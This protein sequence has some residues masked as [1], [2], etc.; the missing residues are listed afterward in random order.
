MALVYRWYSRDAP[1]IRTKMSKSV[2]HRFVTKEPEGLTLNPYIG[3]QHRCV[4]CYATYE[5]SP[6]FY[7]TVYAKLNSPEVLEREVKKWREKEI[8]PVMFSSATDCYQQIESILG[9]TRSC[10]EELQKQGVPYLIITKSSSIMRD[11]ELHARYRDKCA[12]VWSLTTLD[13]KTKHLIEPYTSTAKNILR[14][15]NRF[16]SKGVICGVNIDPIIP[17]ITDSYAMLKELVDQCADNGARFISAGML[18]LRSDIW[19]RMKSFM[20][21]INRNDIV[22]KFEKIYFDNMVK[23]SSYILP[24]RSYSEPIIE[25]VKKCVGRRDV[26]FGFP[27]ES[28]LGLE[29]VSCGNV[30]SAKKLQASILEY[31]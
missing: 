22:K 24:D 17:C 2:L 16:S 27:F 28:S 21:S 6:E 19:S 4:Y 18:R 3:C 12:I 25:F 7:D 5:W 10:V 26:T 29:E 13:E 15:I 11:L 31:V 20:L 30:L 23:S 9:L 8:E 14:T 1:E